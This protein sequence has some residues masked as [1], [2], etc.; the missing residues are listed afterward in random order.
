MSQSSSK[1]DCIFCT[2]SIYRI[3]GFYF[4]ISNK[5]SNKVVVL[6]IT[7]ITYLLD[8]LESGNNLGKTPDHHD[9]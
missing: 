7:I 8:L 6:I 3:I 4:P 1:S 5:Q 9:S 2:I